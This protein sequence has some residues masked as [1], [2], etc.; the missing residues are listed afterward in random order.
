MQLW[1][2]KFTS[3][4]IQPRFTTRL[5]QT[6]NSSSQSQFEY[7]DKTWTPAVN[8]IRSFMCL[9]QIQQNLTLIAPKWKQHQLL[10][11]SV[12]TVYMV[13]VRC[14]HTVITKARV[15]NQFTI[16]VTRKHQYTFRLLTFTVPRTLKRK[17][18]AE[19][20]TCTY[21]GVVTDPEFSLLIDSGLVQFPIHDIILWH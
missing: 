1:N 8:N 21:C 9:Q 13:N 16:T 12:W 19:H 20:V 2:W 6:S 14:V 10:I 11:W 17:Y 15:M 4:E 7:K 18:V 5:W 3:R